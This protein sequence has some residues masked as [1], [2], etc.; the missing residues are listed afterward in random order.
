MP[1]K[2]NIMSGSR[3][4]FFVDGKPVGHARGVRVTEEYTYEPADVMGN[5]EV[6]EYVPTGYR[7]RLSCNKFRIIN[8]SL[9][10]LGWLPTVGSKPEDH[11]LNVLTSGDLEAHLDAYKVSDDG[12][13]TEQVTMQTFEQVKVTTHNWTVDSRGLVGEDV[14]FVAIRTRDEADKI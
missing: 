7:V 9:K 11:L 14:E 12:K 2:R 1:Q 5:I 4:R 3:L 6:E 13:T 8:Q 10:A